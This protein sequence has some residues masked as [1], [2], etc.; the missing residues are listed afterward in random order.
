MM[1]S[2]AVRL[3]SSSSKAAA[4]HAIADICVV[5]LGVGV[6]V[7]EQVA[8]VCK[9]LKDLPNLE[10]KTHAYGT[11]ISGELDEVLAAVAGCHK[12]LHKQHNVPRISTTLK[13]GTRIDK[14]QTMEDKLESVRRRNGKL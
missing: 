7:G 1:R 5:P 3:L 14:A 11:N 6:S 2:T 10:T 9:Y 4:M 8:L 13:I 12:F